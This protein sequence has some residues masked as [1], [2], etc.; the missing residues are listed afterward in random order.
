MTLHH[1]DLNEA[2]HTKP[3]A[4]LPRHPEPVWGSSKYSSL[5]PWWPSITATWMRYYTLYVQPLCQGTQSQ[6]KAAVSIPHY[7][8]DDPPWLQLEWGT[9]HYIYNCFV[10]APRATMIYWGSSKY[11]SLFPWWPSITATWMRYY[12]LYLQPL[13]QGTQSQYEAAV[14]I[15]HYFPDDP[16]SLQLEWGTTN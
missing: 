3:I 9:T 7:F 8:P 6:Y 16:P 14:S 1:C 2:S 10:K 13:C 15:P 11:S 12:T 4:T 5:F